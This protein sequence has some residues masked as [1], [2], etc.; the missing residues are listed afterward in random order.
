MVSPELR[1]VTLFPF[2]C[3]SAKLTFQQ[4]AQ[5]VVVE[6]AVGIEAL[7]IPI[8]SL[9]AFVAAPTKVDQEVPR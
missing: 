9:E 3:A 6:E 4:K 1:Q 2:S 5:I 7:A 8:E